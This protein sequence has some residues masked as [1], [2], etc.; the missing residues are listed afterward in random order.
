VKL[1]ERFS[2]T[3]A[4]LDGLAKPAFAGLPLV[5]VDFIAQVPWVLSE[6]A[7][8]IKPRKPN[9]MRI[10][11]VLALA[12]A[13][14]LLIVSIALWQV[15]QMPMGRAMTLY[16]SVPVA[17]LGIVAYWLVLLRRRVSRWAGFRRRH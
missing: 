3:F 11:A 15:F 14:V 4:E 13:V 12:A 6:P 17:V 7:P 8:V 10:C 1:T 16:A 9:T 2:V 5:Q